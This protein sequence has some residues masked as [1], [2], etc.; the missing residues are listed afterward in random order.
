[1]LYVV[2]MY[3]KLLNFTRSIQLLQLELTSKKESSVRRVRD[4][5]SAKRDWCIPPLMLNVADNVRRRL[6]FLMRNDVGYSLFAKHC[7]VCNAASGNLESTGYIVAFCWAES[8]EKWPSAKREVEFEFNL[9]QVVGV[10]SP[11]T[12][13]LTHKAIISTHGRPRGR[14]AVFTLHFTSVSVQYFSSR[15]WLRF[16]VTLR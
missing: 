16:H 10:G 15:N 12:E 4:L 13:Q 9:I 2:Y 6:N 3:R 1:M 14:L 7:K 8:F 11:I 5:I